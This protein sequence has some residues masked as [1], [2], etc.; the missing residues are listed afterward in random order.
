MDKNAK[1]N[2]KKLLCYNIVNNM[3]CL[4]KNKCMFAHD[5]EEQIKE[6]NRDF[7]YNMIYTMN[8]LSNINIKEN[9]ELFEELLIFTK[10]CKNCINNKCP[11]GYN[12]KYGV[13]LKKLKICYNDLLYGKCTL[14]LN[15]E[16]MN[17]KKLKK[18]INGIHLTEKNLI[19]FY[20]RLSC[21]INI[22]EN[23]LYLLNNINYYSKINTLSIMLNDNTIK[24]VKNLINKNKITKNDLINNNLYQKNN[25]YDFF[26][27]STINNDNQENINENYCDDITQENEENEEIKQIKKIDENINYYFWR[28]KLQ[29]DNNEI[30]NQQDNQQDKDMN[31][32]KNS[33]QT[34]KVINKPIDINECIKNIIDEF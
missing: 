21:E 23:G 5:I 19:P 25:N 14:Q 3:K 7:I 17:N 2:F 8:D 11:G 33:K 30:D 4:Y 10:E 20:Q 6:P 29:N 18:C 34:V 16:Q 32:E 22:A 28:Y 1:N 26:I 15:E 9:R 24:I 31:D 13:C 27:N 12:C